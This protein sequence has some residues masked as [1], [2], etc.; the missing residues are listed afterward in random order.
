M[1]T[2]GDVKDWFKNAL[3]VYVAEL[4]CSTGVWGF[5]FLNSCFAY[6]ISCVYMLKF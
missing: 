6:I 1:L 3:R 4:I 2:E 5:K